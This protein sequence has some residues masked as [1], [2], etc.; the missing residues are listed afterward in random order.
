M[1]YD[2]NHCFA[3]RWASSSR[4]SYLL[5]LLRQ[6]DA[7]V[8]N[9]VPLLRPLF[10][11][12]ILV[13]IRRAAKR[14][15]PS[16]L[17]QQCLHPDAVGAVVMGVAPAGQTDELVDS[18]VADPDGVASASSL[19]ED[20]AAV[21]FASRTVGFGSVEGWKAW[22]GWRGELL[23]DDEGTRE[24]G[25]GG[26]KRRV[27]ISIRRLTEDETKNRTFSSSSSE[28]EVEEVGITDTLST[29]HN[30]S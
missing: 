21:G 6:E 29:Q 10:L 13:R 30:Q 24:R 8:T 28:D 14:V 17:L 9:F 11:L 3:P 23:R 26:G 2:R 25:G 12:H 1:N 19:Y 15:V 27:R 4:R 16:P 18:L 20:G 5:A 22:S 7:L